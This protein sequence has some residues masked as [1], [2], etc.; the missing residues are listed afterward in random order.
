[1][2]EDKIKSLK[3]MS[4]KLVKFKIKYIWNTNNKLYPER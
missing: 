1:M 3:D 2:I 4:N